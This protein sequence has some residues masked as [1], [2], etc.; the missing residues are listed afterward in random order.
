[1]G[2]CPY[3]GLEAFGPDDAPFFFGREKR[4]G[5]LVS[6]IRREVRAAQGVRFLGVLGPS[7][8]GKSSLVLAGLVPTLWDGAIE[9]SE[10]WPVAILRPGGDPLKNL[11]IEVAGRFLA[12]GALPDVAQVRK[13][14][15]ELRADGATLDDFARMALRG[16][17]TDVRLVVVVD[18][19]EEVF[20]YRPREGPTR[21]RFEHDRVQFLTNLLDA[22]ASD[23]G[24][25][26]VVLTMRSDFLDACASFPRL[27]AVLCS[28]QELVGPMTAS[29]LRAA[30]ERPAHLVGLEVESGLTQRLLADVEGQPG[31]LPLLEFALTQVWNRRDVDGR[32]TLDAYLEL[33]K[34]DN[35]EPRG[36]E[37]VL[38]RRANEIYRGLPAE[39]QALCRQLFLRLVRPGQGTEETKR[40][41]SYRQLLPGDPARAEAVGKLI[42]SLAAPD[43]RLITT[44]GTHAAE[45][46]VEV[47]HEALIRG[48]S[49]LRTWVD[50]EGTGLR[51]R[52]RMA[53]ESQDWA[54]A[55]PDQQKDFLYT[56]ARLALAREWAASH[57]EELN[58]T[59]LAF[60]AASEQAEQDELEEERRRREAAEAAALR[61]KQLGRRFLVAAIFA[62]GLA[63][64]STGLAWRENQARHDADAFAKAA[65]KSENQAIAAR[66]RAEEE[67]RIAES[68]RLAALSES[69]RGVRLDRAFLLAVEAVRS[70]RTA[71]A[72]ESLFRAFMARPGA[73]AFLHVD[74]GAVK[75]V[76]YSRDGKTVAAAYPGGVVLWDTERGARLSADPLTVPEGD[77]KSVALSPDGKTVAAGYG[78]PSASPTEYGRGGIV[79][80]DVPLPTREPRG[81]LP[82][83]EGEVTSVAFGLDSKILAAG[84]ARR[85]IN[86]GERPGG[87]V[88]L[89][90]TLQRTRMFA[91]PLRST[92][93]G[94]TSVAFSPDG[95]TVAA[96]CEDYYGGVVLWDM[97]EAKP[98]PAEQAV[99]LRVLSVA[100]SPDGRALATAHSRGVA[101]WDIQ[102]AAPQ[103]EARYRS[104]ADGAVSCV[105]YSPDGTNL[106]AGYAPD[107]TNRGSGVVFWDV[108][109]GN[110]EPAGPLT[111]PEGKVNSVAYGPDSRTLAIGY[112]TGGGGG[113]ALWDAG[114]ARGWRP[115]HRL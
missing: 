96:S 33:G 63:A 15:D 109:S 1:V 27:S 2:Q 29:E 13:L 31:A 51:T 11:A 105:A 103:P 34:D 41:V 44:V 69:E 64:T 111:L 25:V 62:V 42:Q 107:D 78:R 61:E 72:R 43:A 92:Q 113:V 112:G 40:R 59:E 97:R 49:Q 17:P 54:K 70:A 68:R 52:D 86:R 32:L 21:E 102:R 65:G 58:E 47:A 90:D 56:G 94:V 81:T 80:W 73:I 60:L 36:I 30:I 9:G 71:E 14:G 91:E 57:R 38:D 104:M 99:D 110:P 26:V 83:A 87:G 28:H 93:G 55:A 48:W 16:R 3:R 24:R 108:K 37:G 95:K 84:Y 115:R 8:S 50:D 18:Q 45:S 7:G 35:G 66:K 22:A 39:Q 6:A 19:F 4:T 100:Y 106:A 114:G 77:V 75:S 12:P 82:V 89:W 10:R 53:E 101:L 67:A 5:W 79:L 20:T 85:P 76:A 74:E 98:R 23:A 88:V 46:T